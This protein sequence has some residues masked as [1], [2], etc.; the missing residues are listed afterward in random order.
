MHTDL[1]SWIA[2]NRAARLSMLTALVRIIPVQFRL[3]QLAKWSAGL[4]VVFAI[5]LLAQKIPRCIRTAP[6]WT[7]L[8]KPQCHLGKDVGILELCSQSFAD[9][10]FR[11]SLLLTVTYGCTADIVGDIILIV[12][13]L[14]L[15]WGLSVSRTRYRL[16]MAIFC[17]SVFTTIV[18]VI[19]GCV[20]YLSGYSTICT[21]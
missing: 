11:F 17:A 16:L 3:H 5:A 7:V 8:A 14:R 18:S 15:L 19:H 10:I 6:Q 9:S 13:P 4:F 1:S 20:S 2:T 21:L 12:I